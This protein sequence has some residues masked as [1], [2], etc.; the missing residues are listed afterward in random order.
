MQGIS[1][2]SKKWYSIYSLAGIFIIGRPTYSVH[3]TELAIFK[4]LATILPY[5]TRDLREAINRT[6]WSW[7]GLE[8]WIILVAI[9]DL[10][11]GI[12]E[13]GM[14][15]LC[16][17]TAREGQTE[18][19]IMDKETYRAGVIWRVLYS[20]WRARVAQTSWVSGIKRLIWHCLLNFQKNFQSTGKFRLPSLLFYSQLMSSSN[21]PTLVTNRGL[22][23]PI[24]NSPLQ[25]DPN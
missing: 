19:P 6:R 4:L 11:Q 21:F 3:Y 12:G 18:R 17:N 25:C 1:H 16:P 14:S 20:S 23:S 22:K 9:P 24:V 15:T 8:P 7:E 5:C 10:T 13:E 2:K